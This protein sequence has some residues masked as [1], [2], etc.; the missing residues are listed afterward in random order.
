MITKLIPGW[1]INFDEISNGVF[2]I[3]LNDQFGHKT[4]IIDTVNDETIE[5]LISYAFDIEKQISKNW[6]L[7][8]YK[9]VLQTITGDLKYKTEF[10]E[11]SF[12]SWIF[13]TLDKRLIYDGKDNLLIFQSKIKDRWSE[14]DIIKKEEL[15]YFIF[16]K[17][18]NHLTKSN[19]KISWWDKLFKNKRTLLK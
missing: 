12:G 9:M 13:E 5:K 1:S 17:Q 3:S 10:D 15:N 7:F 11:T 16:I 18:I 19:S 6:N 2:K 14:V 8:L 4:E